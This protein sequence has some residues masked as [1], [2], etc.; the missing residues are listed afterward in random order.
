MR[1]LIEEGRVYYA[2]AP[3]YKMTYGKE[4]KYAYTDAEKE[5]ILS[6]KGKADNIQRY[7][8]LG[9][10]NPDQ[11]WETTMNPETR[12]MIQVTLED[13]EKAE[14]AVKL[15]MSEVVA[16]RTEWIMENGIYKE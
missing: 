7:K 3:L 9:E 15:C 14:K 11:L 13:A 5:K 2:V 10:M 6:E 1:P 8:G 12:V 4:V 16:P